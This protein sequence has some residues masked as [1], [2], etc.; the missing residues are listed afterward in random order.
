MFPVD[1][2][3]GPT[4]SRQYKAL[5]VHLDSFWQGEMQHNPATAKQSPDAAQATCDLHWPTKKS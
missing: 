3:T 5:A 2:E 4:A 1:F